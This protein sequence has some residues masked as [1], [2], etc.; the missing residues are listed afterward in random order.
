MKKTLLILTSSLFAMAASGQDVAALLT[1]AQRAYLRGET[2]EAKE[3]FELVRKIEPD[4]RVA[5][6][7][8]RRILA[9]EAKE[10]RTKGPGNATEGALKGLIMPKVQFADASLAEALEFLRQKGNQVGGGKVA[11]NFVMQL[12]D[13]TKEKKVTL[14]L[15]NVP[16]TEVLRYIGGLANVSFS[17]D[18]F[19]IVVKPKTVP[20]APNPV[21]GS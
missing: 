5:I 14:T 20:A 6:S 8:L 19:A 1:E 11:I 13:A 3:K 2:A 7:N 10:A 18:H 4:N 17:Y 15:Q 21:P 16:F 12:D 9:D